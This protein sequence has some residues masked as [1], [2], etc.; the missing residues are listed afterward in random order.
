MTMILTLS[1]AGHM[2]QQTALCKVH[3]QDQFLD[4]QNNTGRHI[5]NTMGARK[6]YQFVENTA[7]QGY[8]AVRED[9]ETG[10]PELYLG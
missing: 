6:I 7:G 10:S 5:L 8:L 1:F 9:I 4:K 3:L 2:V